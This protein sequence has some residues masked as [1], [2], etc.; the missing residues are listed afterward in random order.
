MPKLAYSPDSRQDL[1]DIKRYIT[2]KLQNPI[3]AKNVITR[4]RRE[5]H[6][7]KDTPGI[8]PSL[9]SHVPVETDYRFLVCGNYVAYYRVIDNTV[10]VVRILLSGRDYF[11][12]LFP[13]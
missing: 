6:K 9:A 10:Y 7:L 1:Q 11:S 12:I 3:A 13:E 5:I 4:I 2:E 8:G